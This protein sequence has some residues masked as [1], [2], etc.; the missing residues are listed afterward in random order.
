MSSRKIKAPDASRQIGFHLLLVSARKTYLL[1]ALS[2]ALAKID[3]PTVKN[4]I[5]K[6]VPNEVQQI[7][8]L[9]LRSDTG[10]IPKE[11][12]SGKPLPIQGSYHWFIQFAECSDRA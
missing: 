7:L 12:F 4:E 6:Y 1:D 11:T 5:Q 3:Q 2:S 10:C 8:A 9:P